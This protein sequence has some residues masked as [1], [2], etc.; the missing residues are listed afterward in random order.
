[1]RLYFT[2]NPGAP[3]GLG[4]QWFHPRTP[5]VKFQNGGGFP[6]GK[7]GPPKNGINPGRG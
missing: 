4:G 1:M 6:S 7:Y 3:P 5:G 2:I